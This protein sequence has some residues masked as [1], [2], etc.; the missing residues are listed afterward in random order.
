[1]RGAVL[2][3]H[4]IQSHCGWYAGSA[5]ALADAGFAVLQIDR[6][7]SGRN[8][9]ERG[10]AESA[11]Q[12]LDDSRAARD[13]LLRRS[14]QDD[15]HLVGV[16]WGGKLVV[17]AYVRDPAGVKS[18]S[19]VTPGLFPKIG[20]SRPEMAKIGFAMLYEPRRL[21]DIP[22]NDPELFTSV[23]HWQEFLRTDPL[24]LRRCTAGFYLASRRMDRMVSRL[25]EARPI[26]IHLFIADHERIINNDKTTNF[27][28]QLHWPHC[29]ITRYE[30]VRHSL[31]FEG[32][33]EVYFHDLVSF[34]AA[35][36][37]FNPKPVSGRWDTC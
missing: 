29:Q 24:T 4:G 10:H 9:Q 25:P 3:H 16:S 33:P 11:E 18:L 27:I 6:R 12:L 13:E 22:L 32:D 2:Y 35:V 20:V 26:P 31:E 37:A 21:F 7:G 28:R 36:S 15:Y 1:V 8:L 14:G 23:P 30:A 5:A 34:I 17:A 19:L